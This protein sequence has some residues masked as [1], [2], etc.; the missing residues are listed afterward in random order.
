[1]GK[2]ARRSLA[3]ADPRFSWSDVATQVPKSWSKCYPSLKPL[4][5]WMRDL[6]TRADQIREWATNAMPK[7]FWLPGMTYPTGKGSLLHQCIYCVADK[8]VGGI[9]ELSQIT[10][11][12]KSGR[13]GF[14]EDLQ[15]AKAK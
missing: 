10:F 12:P 6:I 2:H 8:G 15:M 14:A 5:S 11:V 13:V 4:G 7:V 1:M 3:W 9:K